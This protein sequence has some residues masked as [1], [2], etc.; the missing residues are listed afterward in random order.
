MTHKDYVNVF[1]KERAAALAPHRPIDHAKDLEPGFNIPYGQI[2]NLSEVELKT[3]KVYIETNIA[4]GFMKRS[5]SH[6]AAPN[7]FAKKKDGGLQLCVEYRALNRAMVKNQ[8][9]LP[10]IPGMLDRLHGVRIFIKL[11]LRN[12]YHLIRI[13]DGDE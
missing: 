9:S 11:D 5:S 8:Y 1:G 3:L 6:A 13:N 4:N 10:L 12:A 2:Y 7:L